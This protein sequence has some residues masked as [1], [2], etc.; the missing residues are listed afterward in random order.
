MENAVASPPYN[1]RVVQQFT[2]MSVVW[3]I[4]GMLVGVIIAAQLAWPALNFNVPWLSFGRLRPLHTNAVIF[5]FGGSALIGTSYYVVQRTCNAVLAFPK[6]A[7][8]TFWG[9][10]VVIVAA[11]I[12]LPLGYTSAKEY[13]ELEWPIDILITLVW[14]SYAIVFFGTIAKRKQAH[15]YVANWFYGAFIIA[16]ALLHVVNNLEIPVSAWKSYSVYAGT[17]DAMVQWWYGHNAVGFFLT[18][19]FLGMMYYYIPVQAQRPVYSY[20]LSIVHFWALI[21]VYMWAGPH[22]L[23]YSSLPD[24]A[25]SVGMVFS[26]VLLAPSWGGM[27]NG[28]MTLSGAWHKLRTDPIIRFMIVALS[29]YGMSTFEGP[30]MSIKTVNALSHNTDWTIGHVHSGALGWV[31][32]IT[33]GATYVMVPRLFGRKQMYSVGW[34]NAHFWLSTIGTVLYIASMWVSGIMQGLMWRAVNTDGT[35]TYNFVQELVE[36][37]PFYVIRLLGGVI[38]LAGMILMAVNVYKTIRGERD[39]SGADNVLQ[40]A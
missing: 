12:T 8:F 19:G 29:F 26:I 21:A 25:Q 22:H 6:L 3:G 30:M 13:A 39:T 15:I 33:I 2:I 7:A 23:H 40:T 32:M 1:Y 14:V 36:R 31:A 28:M 35:L 20:R 18:A 9:W 11:A 4:V 17:I 38:F 34:I 5:A 37:H 10:Q 24:W 27:I 16:I